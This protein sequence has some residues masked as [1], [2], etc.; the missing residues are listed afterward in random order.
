MP[1]TTNQLSI[2]CVRVQWCFSAS[3]IGS[4]VQNYL[5]LLLNVF[6][7]SPAWDPNFWK[8]WKL[9]IHKWGIVGL[10]SPIEPCHFLV[11][12]FVFFNVRLVLKCFCFYSTVWLQNYWSF[13]TSGW[14]L[15]NSG[16]THMANLN[17]Y[18]Q[19]RWLVKLTFANCPVYLRKC[20]FYVCKTDVFAILWVVLRQACYKYIP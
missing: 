14:K 6:I 19:T 1:C 16:I 12:F 18:T 8:F 17:L 13:Y 3:M 9:W 11:D 20:S 10:V 4:L 5:F 2:K 15:A 7:S